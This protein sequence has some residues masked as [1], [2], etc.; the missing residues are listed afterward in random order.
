M[1]SQMKIALIHSHLN[2]RGGSQ[3]YAIEIANNLKKLGIDVDIFCYEYNKNLCYPELTKDLN[4]YYI[5]SREKEN[6]FQRVYLK[7]KLKEIYRNAFVKTTVNALGLDYLYSLYTTLRLARKLSELIKETHKQ[8]DLIFAHE[9]PLSIYAAIEYKKDIKIPIYWFCYD[10]IEKWF[11]EWK[12]EHRR[13]FLRKILLKH[14]Y[15]KYDK[16][17]INKYVDKAAVL[18]KSMVRKYKNLYN[19]V[20][21]IRR[22][23]IPE[24]ILNYNRKNVIRERF[25]LSDDVII[26]FSLTRFVKYKR[27]H[28]LFAMYEKL[29]Y[30]IR[31]KIFIYINSPITDFSYYKWCMEK[32]KKILSNKNIKIDTGYPRNDDDMYDMYLSSDI[33]IFP[34]ENQTWGHAPLEAMSC[35]VATVVSNGCGIHEE[36]KKITPDMVFEVGNIDELIQKMKYLINNETYKKIGEKQK[37]YVRENLTWNKICE[38]YKKDFKEIMKKYK[39]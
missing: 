15:F 5:Y 25:N 20:P 26:I 24:N 31:N 10:T 2:N 14:I 17:L 7:Q 11:L 23:G 30:N 37:K 27:V 28:D 12:E 34:N 3:R 35:G 19:V 4:I 36:I 29:P 38:I 39:N 33:F 9:E 18:D 16:F 1:I 6:T 21:E 22:G 32:Y 13:S 8:Y